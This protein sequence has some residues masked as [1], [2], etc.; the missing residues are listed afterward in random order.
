MSLK[1]KP[2]PV[3]APPAFA[4]DL[5]ESILDSAQKLVVELGGAHL[6]MDAVALRA[7]VSKGGLLHHFPTKHRLVKAMLGRLLTVFEND[8]E[9]IR[10][11]A[12]PTIKGHM[13][14]WVRLMQTAG[15]ELD[16]ISAGLLSAS[17]QDPE[18]L[19]PFSEMMARRND[20]YRSHQAFAPALIILTALD[21]YWTLNALG[22]KA[23]RDHE[24]N[25]F[26][27]FLNLMIDNLP[28]AEAGL[29]D[30]V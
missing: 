19:R 27:S 30:R 9:T 16:R 2:A 28:D 15:S 26:F 13:R 24:K 8:I 5:R 17:A 10:R 18:L 29:L 25:L 11:M 6:T 12:E 3:Q 22:L 20:L 14:A 1:T 7:G 23:L 21:G 4:K